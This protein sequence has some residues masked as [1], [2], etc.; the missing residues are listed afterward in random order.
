MQSYHRAE[1][2]QILQNKIPTEYCTYFSKRLISY[3]DK[4]PDPL[5]LH[6][7]DGTT[8]EC[9]VLIG[10][11]GIKSSVRKNMFTCLASSIQDEAQ[12]DTYRR[13]V[14]ATWSGLVA[15]RSLVP[16]DALR[17]EY[18]NHLAI[19]SPVFVRPCFFLYFEY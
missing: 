10:A 17:E 7:K 6:F 4:A 13:C 1:F 15:Y 14:D 18:P 3:E 2:L 11:D 12:A 8:A 5:V 9:D 19:H 16:A